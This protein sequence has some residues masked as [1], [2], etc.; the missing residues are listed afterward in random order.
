MGMTYPTEKFIT[1]LIDVDRQLSI[2]FIF[3]ISFHKRTKNR[4][5]MIDKVYIYY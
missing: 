5:S 2:S 1:W 3:L 4:K